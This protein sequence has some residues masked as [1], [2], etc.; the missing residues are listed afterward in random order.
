MCAPYQGL[1]ECFRMS[2]LHSS[3]EQMTLT[4]SLCLLMQHR[5]I[6]YVLF[7]HKIIMCLN[8][9]YTNGYGDPIITG[10]NVIALVM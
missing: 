5:I 3:K 4:Q 2:R 1:Q 10:K 7:V 8:P 6:F 9:H